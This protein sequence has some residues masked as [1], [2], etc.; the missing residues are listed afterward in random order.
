MAG[1]SAK[2]EMM[3]VA[4]KPNEAAPSDRQKGAAPDRQVRQASTFVDR[5]G[6]RKPLGSSYSSRNPLHQQ[7]RLPAY[8]PGPGIGRRVCFQGYSASAGRATTR[9]WFRFAC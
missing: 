1:T 4:S 7:S 5:V 9:R 3:A 8:E 2:V 6:G